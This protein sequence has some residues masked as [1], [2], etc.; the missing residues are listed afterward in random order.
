MFRSLCFGL[1]ISLSVAAGPLEEIVTAINDPIPIMDDGT[2]NPRIYSK[3][4]MPSWTMELKSKKTGLTSQ[5]T[6]FVDYDIVGEVT[7]HNVIL[8][9]REFTN[10]TPF[11]LAPLTRIRH[12]DVAGDGFLY[13][14]SPHIINGYSRDFIENTY[15]F[16]RQPPHGRTTVV[17]MTAETVDQHDKYLKEGI[18]TILDDIR[19]HKEKEGN[20]LDQNTLLLL[21][22]SRR[23]FDVVRKVTSTP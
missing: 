14:I 10:V 13:L 3:R 23:I 15:D 2:V 11:R 1:V 21:E 6:A 16:K 17:K 4:G 7:L 9:T 22:E 5:L 12:V 19:S 20:I 8:E 18:Q